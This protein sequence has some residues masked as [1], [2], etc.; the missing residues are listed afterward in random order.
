M[1]GIIGKR[2]GVFLS[3]FSL[4]KHVLSQAGRQTSPSPPGITDADFGRI[5]RF[6]PKGRL[7]V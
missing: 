4:S 5:H 6:A 2:D 3:I 7:R 1:L